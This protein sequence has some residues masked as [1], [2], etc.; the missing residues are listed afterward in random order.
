MW[1]ILIKYVDDGLDHWEVASH[2]TLGRVPYATEEMAAE[3][4]KKQAMKY[5]NEFA[6]VSLEHLVRRTPTVETFQVNK[7]DGVWV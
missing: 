2:P 6:V 1:F 3:F 5:A 4:A 7:G